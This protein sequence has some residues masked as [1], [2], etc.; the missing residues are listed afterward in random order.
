MMKVSP[1]SLLGIGSA[2]LALSLLVGFQSR[3]DVPPVQG[4]RPILSLN[5][6]SADYWWINSQELLLLRERNPA[7]F[8]RYSLTEKRETALPELGERFTRSG[9]L[10]ETLRISGDGLSLLWSGRDKKR[11][12]VSKIDGS[13]Y[14]ET[15]HSIPTL[16]LWR[17]GS[18]S[19]IGFGIRDGRFSMG[20][21]Y[22]LDAAAPKTR[23]PPLAITFFLEPTDTIGA[24]YPG[25]NIVR[26]VITEAGQFLAQLWAGPDT[27]AKTVQLGAA[28]FSASPTASRFLR[29][30]VPHQNDG[31]EV[32][33][34]PDETV[35]GWIV[36]FRS[37][38][39][40]NTDIGKPPFKR[41]YTGFWITNRQTN[42][43]KVIGSLETVRDD[44]A[45][46]PYSVKFTPDA[47]A[48]SYIYQNTL[49][50]L[51]VP[52]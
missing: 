11:T 44:P 3:S 17:V 48:I 35:M 2:I 10:P 18:Q 7:R 6:G 26:A 36:K 52:K 5:A 21:V 24:S 32:F 37:P 43:T 12:L 25:T 31:A 47:D 49:Y 41:Y 4:A 20:E 14:Q 50:V 39:S 33:F 27:P 28:G 19:W 42:T 22:H 16:S 30:V 29:F 34:S 40:H 45:S 46:G 9:G 13:A 51:T 15:K 8:V 23:I 1:L 38:L